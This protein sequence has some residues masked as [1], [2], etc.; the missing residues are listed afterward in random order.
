MAAKALGP[1][2]HVAEA[3]VVVRELVQTRHPNLAVE[4]WVVARHVDVGIAGAMLKLGS[5]CTHG[6]IMTSKRTVTLSRVLAV[7]SGA[8]GGFTPNRLIAKGMLPV[9]RKRPL[10]KARPVEEKFMVCVV[11]AMLKRPDASMANSP[12]LTDPNRALESE[13]LMLGAAA[14]ASRSFP[15]MIEL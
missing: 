5:L 12:L 11:P 7:P 14:S 13:K 6:S 8:I 15:L 10:L 2:F 3:R 1:F 4:E 9:I